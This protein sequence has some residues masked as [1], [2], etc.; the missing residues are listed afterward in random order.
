MSNRLSGSKLVRLI[1]GV[2]LD[3]IGVI[4]NYQE[5]EL[6]RV[7]AGQ[8]V[9]IEVDAYP[10]KISEGRVESIMTGTGSVFS[11]FPPENA[12][13]NFVK[14][15]QRIPVKM[16]FEKETDSGH[17]SGIGMSL[18]PAILVER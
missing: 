15:A 12:T 8:K 14:T 6:E 9:K 13:G 7:K 2:L 11:L 1:T 18:G 5:T 10:G 4:A 17:L 16:A 3:D